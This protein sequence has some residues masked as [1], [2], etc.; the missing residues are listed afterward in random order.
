MGSGP[1]TGT[2]DLSIGDTY[3]R[4]IPSD[5]EDNVLEML[6]EATFKDQGGLFCSWFSNTHLL[7]VVIS[8]YMYCTCTV[9]V[10]TVHVHVQVCILDNYT[11]FAKIKHPLTTKLYT[12]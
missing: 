4:D 2:F 3:I 1:V 8:T 9:L 7:T 12:D 11:M 6:M 10:C 5:V